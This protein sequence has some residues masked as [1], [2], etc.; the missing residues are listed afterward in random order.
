VVFL[1]YVTWRFGGY[2][3]QRELGQLQFQVMTALDYMMAGQMDAAMDAVALLAVTIEQACLDGGRMDL[4]TLL[5]LQEDAPASIF[6]NRQ[7]MSTSR[8]RAFAPL[9]D[10]RWVTCHGR[11][12]FFQI[13]FKCPTLAII[14]GNARKP[15]R[16]AHS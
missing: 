3:R 8:T 15:S 14:F 12:A 13:P 1:E 10:Q 5:C 4:A 2:G 16:V 11:N 6:I 9:A 7:M